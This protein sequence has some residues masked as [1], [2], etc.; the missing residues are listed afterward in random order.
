M[1]EAVIRMIDFGFNILKLRKIRVGAYTGNKGSNA[2]IKKLG[3][4]KEGLLRKHIRS[5]ATG[6]VFDE[7]VYGIFKNEW[8]KHRKKLVK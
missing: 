7:N 4:I 1:S 2:V 3:F 8:L 5:K 6:K